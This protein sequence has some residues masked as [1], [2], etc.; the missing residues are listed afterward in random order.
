M[1]YA[2]RLTVLCAALVSGVASAGAGEDQ[3]RAQF[4]QGISLYE[5][6]KFDQAAVAFQRAYELKPSYKILYN[7]AQAQNQLGHY[8]AALQAYVSYLAE[9]ADA[10][11]AERSR[12][13]KV[14]IARL[15]TLVGMIVIETDVEEATIFVDGRREGSLPLAGPVIVDLGEHELVAKRDGAE[16][17]RELVTVA[18]GQR[19]VATIE[20]AEPGDV[21]PGGV[22]PGP[23]PGPQPSTEGGERIWTWVFLG[24]GAAIAIAGGVI[25]GVSMS[26]EKSLLEDCADGHCPPSDRE[27]GDA[28]KKLSLTA[29]VLYG[30]GAACLVTGI[31]LFF[32]EPD[33]EPEPAIAV[34]AMETVDGGFGLMLDARF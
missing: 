17:H 25:G 23:S 8:A 14:E 30:V 10:V 24:S 3:A 12:E 11:T 32:V 16:I 5:E 34:T 19:I 9:G 13:I 29:D 15:N 1:R 26:R 33:E 27:E 20:G 18:G 31:I 4:E 21:E 22:E 2:A 28:I 6:G 7:I